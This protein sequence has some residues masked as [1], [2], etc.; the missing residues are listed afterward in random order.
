MFIQGILVLLLILG[1]VFI[2][3]K[4][5]MKKLIF[6]T[7][8][9]QETDLDKDLEEQIKSLKIKRAEVSAMTDMVDVEKKLAKLD[10]KMETLISKRNEK[11]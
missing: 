7:C 1:F 2:N 11:E 10:S 9:I 8:G 4:L 3:Y 5:W 6:T